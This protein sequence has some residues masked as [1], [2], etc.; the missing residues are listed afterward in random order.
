MRFDCLRADARSQGG[1]FLRYICFPL[2][3]ADT[4][5]EDT[6]TLGFGQV[7][8]DSQRA[9]DIA[10]F[11][12]AF[13]ERPVRDGANQFFAMI[14][15]SDD[16]SFPALMFLAVPEPRQGKN[17][18]HFDLVATDIQA[19]VERAVS[20]GATKVADF[21]EYGTRWTTMTDP[22]GNVFDIGLPPSASESA[23]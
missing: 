14:P 22:E 12:S 7:V 5:E 11:W 18:M 10:A 8:I 16:R 17:R 3:N 4:E 9:D 6:M 13:L 20:L 1:G 19:A 2:G 21:D 23:G 15:A